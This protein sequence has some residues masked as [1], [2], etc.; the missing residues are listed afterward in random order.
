MSSAL[1]TIVAFVCLAGVWWSMAELALT[2]DVIQSG[3]RDVVLRSPFLESSPG[4]I[5]FDDGY[6]GYCCDDFMTGLSLSFFVTAVS[7]MPMALVA[8][9][10]TR[11]RPTRHPAIPE[12]ARAALFL[13][14]ASIALNLLFA[15]VWF[16]DEFLP[17]SMSAWVWAM[18]GGVIAG[19]AAVP[20]WYRLSQ[21]QA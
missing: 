6:F 1:K 9:V 11:T 5:V 4:L 10:L 17:S 15:W 3:V 21:R 8:F 16:S 19:M 18:V 13:Q 20:A 14:G 2:S 12:F 7:A